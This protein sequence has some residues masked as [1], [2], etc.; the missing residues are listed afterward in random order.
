M[1]LPKQKENLRGKNGAVLK[2]KIGLFLYKFMTYFLKYIFL[3]LAKFGG[4]NLY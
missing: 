1:R 2:F 3:I 4:K